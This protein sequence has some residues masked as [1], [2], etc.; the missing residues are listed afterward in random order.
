MRGRRGQ[1][2]TMASWLD[3][4]I[5]FPKLKI[6]TSPAPPPPNQKI[7]LRLRKLSSSAEIFTYSV[8]YD[9]TAGSAGHLSVSPTVYTRTHTHIFLPILGL[10]M[11]SLNFTYV[12]NPISPKIEGKKTL[13]LN[14]FKL[15]CSNPH[16]SREICQSLYAV[17]P[18]SH[19]L[20]MDTEVL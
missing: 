14:S 4:P 20:R 15:D 2:G 19:C 18:V 12:I 9:S 10:P 6:F 5:F 8:P 16:T 11:T 3:T 7:S 1:G 17:L 13:H